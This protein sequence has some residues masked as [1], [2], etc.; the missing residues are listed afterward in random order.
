MFQNEISAYVQL[1]F[2]HLWFKLYMYDMRAIHVENSET[3][4]SRI[5]GR[6]SEDKEVTTTTIK[7]NRRTTTPKKTLFYYK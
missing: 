4:P 2:M 6:Y 3:R 5:F 1:H 7:K